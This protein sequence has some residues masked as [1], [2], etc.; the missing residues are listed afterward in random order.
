M[1]RNTATV[2]AEHKEASEHR[3]NGRS[4]ELT[5]IL[6]LEI[7]LSVVLAERLM[8]V[9]SILDMKTGTIIEF[10]VPFD[11]ELRLNIGN[12]PIGAGQTVKIG[13]NFGLKLTRVAGVPERV[14]AMGR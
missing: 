5:R 7:T 6:G 9:E 11:S 1:T 14:G 8:T 3:P 13:E 4:P 12:H 10:D 2:T